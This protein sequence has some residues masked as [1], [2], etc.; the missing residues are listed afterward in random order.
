MITWERDAAF[1][2]MSISYVELLLW[3]GS[4]LTLRCSIRLMNNVVFSNTVK[5]PLSVFM[6]QISSFHFHVS[7]I[8]RRAVLQLEQNNDDRPQWP[9][10]LWR[11]MGV[12]PER[13]LFHHSQSGKYIFEKV[14]DTLSS[15]KVV[16]KFSL[17]DVID[18]Y[19]RFIFWFL[20]LSY[21]Y[22]LTTF[23]ESHSYL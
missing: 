8:S 7:F 9:D 20:C 18:A 22:S 2:L 1:V 19:V 3:Y 4:N 17:F 21:A 6:Q 15:D 23:N 16:S 14:F 11:K 12:W 10:G 13:I 5:I